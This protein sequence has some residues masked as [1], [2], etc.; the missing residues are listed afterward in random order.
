MV[1]IMK[2]LS[3]KILFGCIPALLLYSGHS[4]AR[5]AYG[6]IH[7]H[8]VSFSPTVQ[9]TGE[10]YACQGVRVNPDT[11]LTTTGCISDVSASINS[12]TPVKVHTGTGAF[13][14]H[15]R[16]P[17][18]KKSLQGFLGV[19]TQGSP[20]ETAHNY[21]QVHGQPLTGIRLAQAAYAPVSGRTV[22]TIPV[23]IIYYKSDDNHHYTFNTHRPLPPGAPVTHQ[24]K[25][26]CTVAPD[27]TCRAPVTDESTPDKIKQ[28]CHDSLPGI[29]F[30]PGCVNRTITS[31]SENLWELRGKGTCINS[32]SGETCEFSTDQKHGETLIYGEDIACP[33]CNANYFEGIHDGE[34]HSSNTCTPEMCMK[35]CDSDS[36]SDAMSELINAMVSASSG[37]KAQE[38]CDQCL[39]QEQQMFNNCLQ[40][41]QAGFSY[42]ACKDCSEA[43]TREEAYCQSICNAGAYPVNGQ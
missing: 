3:L 27:G 26:V 33:S 6:N 8:I 11:I 10:S 32:M 39:A 25:V 31:C 41:C 18:E 35:G 5:Q 1:F 42:Q 17:S 16:L 9:T 14:G 15:I 12:G 22:Q 7:S 28:D 40:I 21:P 20:V 37:R 23:M 34:H 24:G 29:Y 38:S 4:A 36:R 43:V 30:Y 2:R 13:L 19:D